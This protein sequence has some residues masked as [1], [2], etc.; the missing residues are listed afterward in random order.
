MSVAAAL[1]ILVLG[2]LAGFINIVGQYMISNTA[3][4]APDFANGLFLT[5]AN[6]GTTVGTAICGAFI[7]VAG[8]RYSLIGTVLFL[9]AS[10]PFIAARRQITRIQIIE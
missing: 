10:L 7:T 8:T 9:A 2:I 5:A 1:L 6:W 3:V 4:E